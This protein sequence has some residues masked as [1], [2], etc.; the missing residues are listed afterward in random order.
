M[1]ATIRERAWSVPTGEPRVLP[2]VPEDLAAHL[3]AHGPVPALDATGIV[4]AVRDAGLTGRGGA[5]FPTWRKLAAVAEAAAVTPAATEHGATGRGAVVVGNGAEGEPASA[6]DRTLLARAPHLVL[7]G[8]ALAARA[9]G[10]T[11]AHLYVPENL[12]APLRSSIGERRRAGA[13]EG[14][15]ITVH[16]AP[17]AFIAGEESAV[18]SALA[19]G[20]AT[21]RDTPVR[22]VASGLGGRPTLVQNVETLANIAL[23]CRYGPGRFRDSGTGSEPG[24]FLATI[25]GP[26]R[27]P[28]VY[29]LPLG[30]ALGEAL[31]AAGGTTAPLRAVLVGGY[32]GGWVPAR[33]DLP[34]SRAGLEP[35]GA[36]PG[37]GVVLPL[38]DDECGLAVGARIA[39]YLARQSAGQCGPCIN[40]LPRL[41]GTLAALA[42]RTGRPGLPAEVERLSRLVTGRGACRHPDGT[43]RFVAST[44]RAFAADVAA[45]LSGR[46]L[47]GVPA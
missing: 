16:T 9:T 37:A 5:A 1:T 26:V 2:A 46:C 42:A 11:E 44:M 40:G 43:A 24:T 14:L 7:D 6:K 23:I 25:G 41:A 12:V 4:A 33:A 18:V 39:A 22:V 15:P 13:D 10:A 38:R 47:I 27:R 29:E 35:F 30:V 36:A 32:H 19:G 17:R 34:L 31:A 3:R 21:P 20:P 8:L 45:H 28:G